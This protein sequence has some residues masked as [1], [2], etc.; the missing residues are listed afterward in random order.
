MKTLYVVVLPFALLMTAMG[1]CAPPATPTGTPE[2]TVA[3]TATHRP[4]T[5][6]PTCTP[7]IVP[8]PARTWQTHSDATFG[9][10]LRH[11]AGWLPLAGYERRY[12]GPDGFFQLSAM[13]GAGWTLDEVADNEAHHKLQPYGSK[14][15]IE[16]LLVQGREARLV[17]PSADQPKEMAGQ[18]GL[19]VDLPGPIQIAGETYR[20]LILWADV[21]HIRDMATT[22]ELGT[23]SPHAE[24]PEAV[25][26]VRFALAGQFRLGMDDIRLLQWERVDWP[27]GCLG[28]PMRSMCTEAIVPGYRIMLEIDGQKY[29]Y[30]SD[31][32]ANVFLLAAGPAHGIEQPALVWEGEELQTLLLAADGR[33]AVGP[34][35]A[36]LTLLRLAQENFRPQQLAELLASFAPFDAETPSG[37]VSFRGQGEQAASAAWRRAVGAWALLVHAELE[38]GR[39]GASWGTALSWRAQV[40]DRAGFCHFLQVEEYG[41]AFASV[42]RCEGG[43]AQDQGRAWLTGSELQ[44]LDVWLY[45]RAPLDLPDLGLFSRGS[46]PMAGTEISALRAWAEAVYARLTGS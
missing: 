3:P 34:S 39:S 16:P 17:L 14:P 24:P 4:T 25:Q 35:G 44:A 8:T 27:N 32:K 31:L 19:I 13:S 28:I 11:P 29:E 1:A 5:P 20:F 23:P 41:F 12:A 7:T 38:S 9:I 22:L 30:R 2:P 46:E 21:E 43:E 6:V 36:P 45:D 40:A 26:Q 10:S 42:A 18:A 33:A 15:R 37:H